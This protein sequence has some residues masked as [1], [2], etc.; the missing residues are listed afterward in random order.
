MDGNQYDQV[1]ANN[2]YFAKFFQMNSNRKAGYTLKL[3][4]Q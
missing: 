4:F 2:E 1:F 3:L